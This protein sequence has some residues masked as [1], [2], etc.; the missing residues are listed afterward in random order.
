MKRIKFSNYMIAS[1]KEKNNIIY[2][3]IYFFFFIEM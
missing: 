2:K 3:I 1:L